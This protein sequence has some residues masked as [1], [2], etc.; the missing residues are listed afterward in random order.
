[1]KFINAHRIG[2]KI[3]MITEFL[4]FTVIL[5]LEKWA[6]TEYFNFIIFSAVLFKAVG[7][8]SIIFYPIV[9]FKSKIYELEM[10]KKGE[11]FF[12]IGLLTLFFIQIFLLIFKI[13]VPVFFTVL[14]NRNL[15]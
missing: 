4:I 1:M 6:G 7:Y 9:K 15:D 3:S 12:V 11:L 8:A 14:P 13:K 10:T 5:F 2:I